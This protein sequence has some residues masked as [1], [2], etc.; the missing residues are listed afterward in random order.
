MQNLLKA[1]CSVLFFWG[2]IS[3]LQAQD[4]VEID[5][6]L[7]QLKAQIIS[8]GDST[9]VPYAT[10]INY[11]TKSGTRTNVGGYFS[12]EMLNI[13]SLVI[14]AVGFKTTV[15]RVPANF[16][17]HDMLSV[18]L[19]P[20]VYPLQE[21]QVKGE[22]LKVNMD[23]IPVGK[24]NP[25]PVELRGDAFSEKPPILAAFFNPLSYMQYYF[26]RKEKGKRQVRAA[27]QTEKLWE[28]HSKNY[29]RDEVKRLTGLND[30]QADDFIIWFNAQGVLPYTASEYEIQV[31]I[32]KYFLIYSREKSGRRD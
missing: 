23:G 17:D 14:S 28:Q 5:P 19:E 21:V 31:S 8:K 18:Y 30:E 25:V 32:R 4:N 24:P 13:D 11:R 29:N 9:A 3:H 6:M 1:I 2:I 7:I 15:A 22:G 12:M 10:V 20:V 26:S 16:H 27:I